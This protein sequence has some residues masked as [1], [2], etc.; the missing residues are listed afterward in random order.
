[1]RTQRNGLFERVVQHGLQP[2]EFTLQ[3]V[4]YVTDVRHLPTESSFSLASNDGLRYSGQIAIGAY[5]S[6]PY[7][8]LNWNGVLDAFGQWVYNVKLEAE[9]PD[10]WGEFRQTREIVLGT[11]Q[12]D[13]QNTP[14]TAD[15]QAQISAQLRE[16]KEYLRETYPK[17]DE[18]LALIEARL[19]E[20]EEASRR[21]GRKD[22]WIVFLG[23]ML[24]LVV[25]GF[26]TPDVVHHIIVMIFQTLGQLFSGNTPP[27]LPPQA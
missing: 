24:P 17:S 22:W 9:T 6:Y 26:V 16:I 21:I 20:A 13:S 14:F 15:E 8:N 7:G 2:G 10:M 23:L 11:Q 27:Q 12:K 19:D 5:G 1:M 3:D 4:G 18:R 25:T